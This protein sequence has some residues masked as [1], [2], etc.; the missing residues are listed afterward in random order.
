MT[1]KTHL[2]TDRFVYWQMHVVVPETPNA[3]YTSRRS[4][5]IR[6]RLQRRDGGT[7]AVVA[8]VRAVETKANVHITRKKDSWKYLSFYAPIT[9][10]GGAS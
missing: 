7:S 3:L 5:R 1:S 9:K 2:A 4:T 8:G 6:R 10:G